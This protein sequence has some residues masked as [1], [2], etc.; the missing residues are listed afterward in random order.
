LMGWDLRDGWARTA[1]GRWARQVIVA[2]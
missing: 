1:R 2:I